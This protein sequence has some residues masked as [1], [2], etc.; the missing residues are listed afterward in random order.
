MYI[1][2]FKENFNINEPKIKIHIPSTEN[3]RGAD[4]NDVFY[5]DRS[6]ATSDNGLIW[7]LDEI[8]KCRIIR[9]WEKILLS[10][11]GKSID[12]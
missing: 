10:I 1:T 4:N 3:D 2:H 5:V 9:A 7:G 6:P 12:F 8:F 11:L